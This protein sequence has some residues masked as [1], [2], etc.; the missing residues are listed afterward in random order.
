MLILLGL[1]PDFGSKYIP[2]PPPISGIKP[3]INVMNVKAHLER[4]VVEKVELEEKVKKLLDFVNN[5]I[6]QELDEQ[7]KGLLAIQGRA[8]QT[9]LECLELRI[10]LT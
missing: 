10:K 8:M 2:T 3:K 1:M 4:M 9:Y 5:P 7:T 6:Y